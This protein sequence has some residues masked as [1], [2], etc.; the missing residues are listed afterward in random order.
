MLLLLGLWL[1]G[2]QL[3]AWA[4]FPAGTTGGCEWEQLVCARGWFNR[5]RCLQ[6]V[7]APTQPAPAAGWR[8]TWTCDPASAPRYNGSDLSRPLPE[9]CGQDGEPAS[10]DG[11]LLDDNTTRRNWECFVQQTGRTEWLHLA[12]HRLNVS[13]RAGGANLSLMLLGRAPSSSAPPGTTYGPVQTILACEASLCALVVPSDPAVE[14]EAICRQYSCTSCAPSDCGELVG[15]P[16]AALVGRMDQVQLVVTL[17]SL[18]LHGNGSALASFSTN[19]LTLPAECY[20]GSCQGPAP[21]PHSNYLTYEYVTIAATALCLLLCTLNAA[22][23]FRKH[24]AKMRLAR[25]PISEQEAAQE[26]WL[27]RALP[28]RQCL[29]KWRQIGYR[30]AL[31]RA[32]VCGSKR[33]HRQVISNVSGVVSGGELVALMG[34]S[35][36]GKTTLL[37]ILTGRQKV[38]QVSGKVALVVDGH[39]MDRRRSGFCSYVP[40]DADQLLLCTQT[41]Y[42]YVYFSA[43]LR[44]PPEQH[45]AR[46]LHL[47]VVRVLSELGL[48]HVLHSRIGRGGDGQGGISTGERKRV[49]IALE[50]ITDPLV[51]LLD[52]PTSGLDSYNATLLVEVIKE[53]A[54]KR[55]M[56]CIASIHQPPSAVYKLCDQLVLLT[57]LGRPAYVGPAQSAMAYLARNNFPQPPKGFSPAEHLLELA[58]NQDTATVERLV[59]CWA[60]SPEHAALLS[61]LQGNVAAEPSHLSVNQQPA[62]ELADRQASSPT[63]QSPSPHPANVSTWEVAAASLSVLD[64]HPPDPTD[65]YLAGEAA[66]AKRRDPEDEELWAEYRAGSSSSAKSASRSS[67]QP[68]PRPATPAAA[69]AAAAEPIESFQTTSVSPSKMPP[70]RG[71]LGQSPVVSVLLSALSTPPSPREADEQVGR[72]TFPTDKQGRPVKLPGAGLATQMALLISRSASHIWRDSTL[73]AFTYLLALLSALVLG[74]IFWD[75]DSTFSGTQDRAGFL[76]F[77]I[78]FFSLG[79]LSL[80]SQHLEE[81]HRFLNERDAGYYGTLPFMV[82]KL[83][84]DVLPLRI[85]PPLLFGATTYYMVGLKPDARS[86]LIFLATLVLVNVVTSCACFLIAVLSPDAAT[87]NLVAVVYLV[88]CMLFAGLF[89]NTTQGSPSTEYL[90]WMQYGSY[91]YFGYDI[92]MINELEGQ[93]FTFSLTS[94]GDDDALSYNGSFILSLLSIKVNQIPTDLTGLAVM[95]GLFFGLAIYSLKSQNLAKR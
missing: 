74:L 17:A 94:G 51:L 83:V 86:F 57:R 8:A 89:Y 44:L 20:A 71:Q 19:S 43:A 35:G 16:L 24:Q 47:K 77:V 12:D 61:L 32:G 33:Q 54:T 2:P 29:F 66:G 14:R 78:F 46:R 52:E 95:V 49:A 91:F 69:A 55:G 9:A 81:K 28:R 11:S 62:I 85:V 93:D 6:Y 88:Y 56:L 79:S 76:F 38:G 64:G 84:A 65:F 45:S 21:Q 48:G 10:F 3:L 70:Q 5:S 75:L 23:A 25:A 92:L 31:G 50:L 27:E 41:V 73:L 40:V 72:V 34:L 15:R 80:L 1:V 18:G 13:W 42:E 22:Y 90:S 63:A 53:Q 36:A 58:S 4:Q 39:Q 59:H 7:G 68:S 60:K 37:D 30:V 87:A 82:S 26:E 67:S